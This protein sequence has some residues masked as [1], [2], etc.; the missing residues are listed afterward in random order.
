MSGIDLQEKYQITD[1]ELFG[2]LFDE[3]DEE[4]V[5]I[6]LPECTCGSWKTYGKSTGI[7][8]E[9]CDITRKGF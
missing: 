5:E 1:D 7:H 6:K 3:E 2:D 9:W 8:S 4:T